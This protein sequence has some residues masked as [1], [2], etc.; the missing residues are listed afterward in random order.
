MPPRTA[1]QCAQA[2]GLS[3]IHCRR[4]C[5]RLA[6]SSCSQGELKGAFFCQRLTAWGSSVGGREV[7]VMKNQVSAKL[8]EY[9]DPV[10]TRLLTARFDPTPRRL[11]LPGVASQ[12]AVCHSWPAQPVCDDCV[13]RFAAPQRRCSTCALTLPADLSQGL[14]TLPT[15]CA[16]CRRQPFGL[17]AALA[18]LTYAYPWSTLMARYKFGD[19]PA[20]AHFFAR[21]LLHAPGVQQALD[22]LQAHDLVLPMPLS[23][24]RLQTRG[25]N[26]AWELARALSRQ[27]QTRARADAR[28]LLR[29]KHTR[30]QSQLNRAAR[31]GNVRGAFQVE[32]LRASELKGRRVLLVD[33]VMT[34]GASLLAAAQA[35]REAGAAHITALVLA[36]TESG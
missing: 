3:L 12:C 9:I 26:Q 25:F 31:L 8:G 24:E 34:S 36:R 32:P 17:D 11:R 7:D 5:I 33:D 6:T 1:P 23:A 35:L 2:A 16:A 13:T 20:W 4:S 28:L 27:S 10:F 29:L 22:E 14:R 30:P 21:L 19:E 18:G 15:Q